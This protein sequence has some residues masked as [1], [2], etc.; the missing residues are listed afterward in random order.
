M[1]GTRLS[2]NFSRP[3]GASLIG[4]VQTK[5]AWAPAGV[6]NSFDCEF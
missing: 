5:G 2:A 3:A 1:L 6:V 4:V